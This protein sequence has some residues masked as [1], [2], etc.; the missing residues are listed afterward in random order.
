MF[1]AS[2]FAEEFSAGPLEP[3]SEEFPCIYAV[4]QRESLL[5]VND[6]KGIVWGEKL[7]LRHGARATVKFCML[8]TF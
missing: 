8:L 4:I 5:A 3:S 7:S 2:G 1:E 6:D